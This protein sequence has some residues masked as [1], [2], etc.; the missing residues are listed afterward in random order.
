MIAI[1]VEIIAKY[2]KKILSARNVN[3]RAKSE[4]LGEINF[5]EQLRSSHFLRE[6]KRDSIIKKT[7]E[8]RQKNYDILEI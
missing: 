7:G 8:R 6:R 3:W 1:K 2:A 5:L 4:L